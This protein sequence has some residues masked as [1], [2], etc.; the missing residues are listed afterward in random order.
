[1]KLWEKIKKIPVNTY[2]TDHWKSYSEFIPKEKHVQSKALTYTV[3]SYNSRIRH[4]L[5]RFR[6]RTKCYTKKLYMM[7]YSLRLLI[8]KLNGELPVFSW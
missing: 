4:Y 3:E 1:M 8:L 5:A 2:N 6:R 7:K